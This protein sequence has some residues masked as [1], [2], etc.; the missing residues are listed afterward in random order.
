MEGLP[1]FRSLSTAACPPPTRP[2]HHPS[3]SYPRLTSSLPSAGTV[4]QAT[5]THSSPQSGLL[6]S[7][8]AALEVKSNPCSRLCQIQRNITSPSLAQNALL[9]A[10]LPGSSPLLLV[11]HVGLSFQPPSTPSCQPSL[12]ILCKTSRLISSDPFLCFNFF[13]TH[14]IG[15]P[16]GSVDKDSACNAEDQGSIPSLEK[17]M[18][19]HSSILA[20]RIPWTEK[21]GGLESTR[22]QRVRH[23]LSTKPPPPSHT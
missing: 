16:G 9:A 13:I 22:S 15:L 2:L 7:A 6:A 12:F 1:G 3:I 4:V 20:W 10:C 18:A 21:P 23:T 8:P 11:S 17:K 14:L 19:T 5:W